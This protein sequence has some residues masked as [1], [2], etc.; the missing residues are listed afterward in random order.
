M[1]EY[2]QRAGA[3]AVVLLRAVRENPFE[4]IVILVHGVKLRALR[5]GEFSGRTGQSTAAIRLTI[6][7]T[8]KN[9]LPTH[10]RQGRNLRS[11]LNSLVVRK[12]AQ[13]SD[14]TNTSSRFLRSV[15]SSASTS[16]NAAVA[17]STADSGRGKKNVASPREISSARRRFSSISGPSTIPSSNGAGSKSC[18]ISQ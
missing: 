17:I 3:G 4:Q 18:L 7:Y 12:T 8:R 13:V 5:E 9:E 11:A 6:D 16:R 2:R 15:G 14:S 10:K 1:A